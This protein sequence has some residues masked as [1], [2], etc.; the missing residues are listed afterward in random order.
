MTLCAGLDAGSPDFAAGE[1][2]ALLRCLDCASRVRLAG[3]CER[4]GYPELGVDG[5]LCCE[6]CEARYPL[7]AGTPRMLSGAMRARLW[8]DYPRSA[9]AL[10]RA[11]VPRPAAK[12]RPA[13]VKQRTADSFAYEWRKFGV[14]RE[15]WRKNFIDY[16]Q[17]HPPESFVG[18]L[19]LDVGTG[20]G[21]H[22]LQAALLGARVV[23][24][25]IG[26]SIDVARANLPAAALTVQADA[27][28]LPFAPGSFDFV[29]SVGVLHHL[30]V[31]ERALAQI[32]PLA[33]PGG[34]VH[35]YV[36]WMPERRWQ[37]RVLAGVAAVRRMTVRLPHPLLHALCIP[38]AA[39]LAVGVVWPYRL[40]RRSPRAR[41]LAE[42][43]PLKTY[44][45]YPFAVLVN[46][47][48]DRFSA[49]LERR[50]R[51]EEVQAMLAG[52]GLVEVRVLPNHGWIGDG[53]MPPGPQ[54]D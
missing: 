49:P 48:F 7:I 42:A 50:Y 29:M 10:E 35:I 21:R 26:G 40:L 23:A 22:A 17:P 36:Y 53:L 2:L 4:P 41:P 52:A 9:S 54:V 44:A 34:S 6:A 1:L 20:S 5:W 32:A 14:L 38:L 45:D 8:C 11:G 19:V 39:L 43:L 15:Q 31:P 47:Q 16:M 30:P 33:R 3:L 25:D 28:R 46:D 27:E 12:K 37:A 13:D 24:V 18:R 51:R